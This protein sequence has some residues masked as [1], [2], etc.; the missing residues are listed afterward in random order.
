[1]LCPNAY[2]F[3][4]YITYGKRI[5]YGRPYLIFRVQKKFILIL[6]K[7]KNHQLFETHV[8]P[9]E[10]FADCNVPNVSNLPKVCVL[11]SV[12]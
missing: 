4:D 6:I 11:Y 2:T 9:L 3:A 1:M 7:N 12:F 5:N 8:F 10:S